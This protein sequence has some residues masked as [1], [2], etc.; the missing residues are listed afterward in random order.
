MEVWERLFG[1]DAQ[2]LFDTAILAVNIFILFILLSYILFNPVRAFLKKRQDKV[3]GD[4]ED[5]KQQKEEA[6]AIKAEYEAKLQAAQK[7]IELLLS[8]SRKKALNN[9]EA[10]IKEAKKEAAKIVRRGINQVDLERKKAADEIKK[11]I[12]DVATLMAGKV[13][14]VSVT[15][16]MQSKLIDDTLKDIGDETW[17]S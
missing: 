5:A 12:I 17:L 14:A 6:Y 4:I 15:E 9:E 13:A 16:E 3:A 2:L 10:I 11:E 8:E 7:E 1:L